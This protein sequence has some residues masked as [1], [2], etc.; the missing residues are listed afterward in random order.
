MCMP[1]FWDDSLCN[2][3]FCGTERHQANHTDGQQ[4]GRRPVAAPWS[5]YGDTAA[6]SGTAPPGGFGFG[7]PPPP[8]DEMLVDE[9]LKEEG[10]RGL[11]SLVTDLFSGVGGGG[12]NA[13]EAPLPVLSPSALNGSGGSSP[14]HGASPSHLPSG[15]SPS[16]PFEDMDVALGV[17]GVSQMSMGGSQPP[18]YGNL[19]P[20]G[21]LPANFEE[22]EG[23]SF[24]L[25]WKLPGET[26]SPRASPELT[27]RGVPN[28]AVGKRAP[29]S[30]GDGSG[31]TSLTTSDHQGVSATVAPPTHAALLPSHPH[32]LSQNHGHHPNNGAVGSD[33]SILSN[34]SVDSH[35]LMEMYE[36]AVLGV[37]PLSTKENGGDKHIGHGGQNVNGVGAASG[38]GANGSLSGSML[39]ADELHSLWD[40]LEPGKHERSHEEPTTELF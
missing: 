36:D 40:A 39:K 2:L 1:D 30:R 4:V 21:G 31:C 10:E 17:E 24:T 11:W 3:P 37:D 23:K 7:A 29:R 8:A 15:G 16:S 38:G 22:E 34:L 14:V 35:E 28:A 5:R 19:Q 9:L 25:S 18:L 12:N 20:M 32:S 27:R 26:P 6:K 33:K 13:A